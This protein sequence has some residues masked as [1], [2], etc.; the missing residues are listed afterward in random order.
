MPKFSVLVTGANRGIGLA[1]AERFA[2]EGFPVLLGARDGTAGEGEAARLRAGGFDVQAL[3]LDVGDPASIASAVADIERHEAKIGALV[4][5]AGI[6]PDGALLTMPEDDIAAS[7]A[8]NVMGPLRLI[9][10]LAPG[11]GARGFGR[12][13]NVS[14]G[15]GSFAQGLGP[16]AYGVTKA[17]LNALT[18][19]AAAE[20]PAA[21]KCNAMCPGWVRTRMGGAGATLAPEVPAHTAFWLGTLPE[22]GPTG[23]FFRDK[24]PVAW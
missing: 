1:I 19:R 5:N 22:D 12:I 13:V 4:N 24:K 16:G 10:A 23:G 21:V 14:S 17:A 11:M 9:R 2:R 18:V 7:F 8:I 3:Q 6:L 15:W 20:L